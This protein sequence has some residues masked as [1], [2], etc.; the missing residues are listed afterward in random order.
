MTLVRI[1]D[2]DYLKD[3][4]LSLSFNNGEEGTVDLKGV[5]TG[6]VY[7]PLLDQ[8]VFVQYGLVNGTLEWVNKADFAPEFLYDLMVKQQ[9]KEIKDKV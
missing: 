9:K 7:S 3:Y 2:V 8:K 4:Q 1:T 5:L 6:E